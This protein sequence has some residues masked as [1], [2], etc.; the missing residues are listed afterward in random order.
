MNTKILV[1]IYQNFSHHSTILNRDFTKILVIM[2]NNT[3]STGH[4]NST[5]ETHFTVV[6]ILL[7]PILILVLICYCIVYLDKKTEEKITDKV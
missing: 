4:G 3:L 7:V 2:G 5:D 1:E 6:I